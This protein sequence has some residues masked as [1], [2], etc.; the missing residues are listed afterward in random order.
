M[1]KLQSMP[2][3]GILKQVIGILPI[4][5]GIYGIALLVNS[6]SIQKTVSG[7]GYVAFGSAIFFSDIALRRF[8]MCGSALL[9]VGVQSITHYYSGDSARLIINVL[10]L[11]AIVMLM[12]IYAR[13]TEID[14]SEK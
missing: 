14:L 2:M 10:M 3:N 5:F 7:L 4:I 8:I 12:T 1:R 11:I 13:K 6:D 9:L